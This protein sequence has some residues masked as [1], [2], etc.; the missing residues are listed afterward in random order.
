VAMIVAVNNPQ[1]HI[2]QRS[3]PFLIAFGGLYTAGF[4]GQ[5]S[6]AWFYSSGNTKIPAKIGAVGFSLGIIF[7]V[8]LFP[9]LGTTAVAAG[10]SLN[11]IFNWMMLHRAILKDA[12]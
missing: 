3:V 9:F 12:K 5:L 2:I 7:R 6:A 1:I 11:Q 4:L 8:A 10:M